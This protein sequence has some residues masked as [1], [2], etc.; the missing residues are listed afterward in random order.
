MP[1]ASD[2][3]E[4]PL[5]DLGGAGS[6]RP[7]PV[8]GPMP[9]V[10]A[11]LVLVLPAVWVTPSVARDRLRAW[12]EA[13]RWSRAHIEELV[14]AVSEAVSNSIE[15]GYLVSPEHVPGPDEE[16]EPAGELGAGPVVELHG[17][18]TTDR[19]GSRRIELTVRDHGSWIAR[20]TPSR[21]RGQGLVMMRA[22]TDDLVIDGTPT[23]TT[24]LLRSRPLPPPPRPR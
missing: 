21:G 1:P 4:R 16:Q 12:L 24:V 20:G 23:G 9:P 15:H 13:H 3:D 17:V 8:G 10:A 5:G 19:A 2:H 14:I 7:E 18:V 6:T 11:T 22:C